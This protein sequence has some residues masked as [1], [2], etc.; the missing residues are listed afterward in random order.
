MTATTEPTDR[1]G[2]A[3]TGTVYDAYGRRI[4]V[5]IG[6]VR[7]GDDHRPAVWVTPERPG[8][9]GNPQPAVNI[10]FDHVDQVDAMIAGL[11][12]ARREFV[13]KVRGRSRRG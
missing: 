11:R 4:D 2:N 1:N 8:R 6:V 7:D 3:A 12:T 9:G 5:G 13:A 10:W